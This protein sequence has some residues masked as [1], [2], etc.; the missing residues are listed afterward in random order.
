MGRI[1]LALC[2]SALMLGTKFANLLSLSLPAI[3]K[4]I[5]NLRLNVA[6]RLSIT[7]GSQVR[8]TW[9]AKARFLR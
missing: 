2:S 3:V 8:A 9:I 6:Q 7:R 5:A 4:F 1:V